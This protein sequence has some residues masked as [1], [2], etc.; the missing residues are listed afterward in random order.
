MFRFKFSSFLYLMVL[1]GLSSL[2]ISFAQDI[3]RG[4]S[5]YQSCIACHGSVGQGNPAERAPRI[6]GQF[7]WYIVTSLKDFK[8]GERLNPEM[9]PYIE[10]LSEQDFID[11]AA[12]ISQLE[13][14][15]LA[16]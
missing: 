16:Q 11:L 13:V 9:Q 8:S 2:K 15:E 12:Y 10:D 5:L 1:C 4:Q 3:E 14:V 6:G 7:D